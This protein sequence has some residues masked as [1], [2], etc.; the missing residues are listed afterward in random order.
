MY[1]Q[2]KNSVDLSIV[3]AK[4]DH[5]KECWQQILSE[6]GI[7][8]DKLLHNPGKQLCFYDDTEKYLFILAKSEDVPKLVN[9]GIADIGFVGSNFVTES[10]YN[11]IVL[12]ELNY[13]RCDL[14]I[15]VD[16]NS[17]LSEADICSV[18][19]KYATFVSQYFDL[20]GKSVEIFRLDGA[21]EIGVVLG[22]TDA[23]VDTV[24]TGEA[25]RENGLKVMKTIGTTSAVI[26]SSASTYSAKKKVIDAYM[27][28]IRP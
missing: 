17:N 19:T 18:T 11:L 23:V 28:K 8:C 2:K 16:K 27:K 24:V 20:L 4:N 15:I 13:D 21:C 5:N 1:H 22:I 26:I 14:C 12:K 25:L 6:T 10:D 7:K 3:I 9:S